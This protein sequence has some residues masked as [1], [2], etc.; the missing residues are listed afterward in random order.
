MRLTIAAEGAADPA[1]AWERYAVPALWPTWSPQIRSVECSTERIAQGSTGTV[2]GPVGVHVTFEVLE[3]D[4]PGRSWVWRVRGPLGVRLR[5]DHAVGARGAAAGG[6]S[7]TTLRIHGLAPVVTA[8]AP[9]AWPALHRL[10][11]P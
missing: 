7:R 2:H 6:G 8:Y 3:V 1:L 10:V 11:S 5:L 9:V 4:E